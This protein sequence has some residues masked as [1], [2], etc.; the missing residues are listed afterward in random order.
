MR[1]RLR[2]RVAAAPGR[3]HFPRRPL[4]I[5]RDGRTVRR[6][7]RLAG[8]AVC[9]AALGLSFASASATAQTQGH[10]VA[11]KMA[12]IDC[13][14]VPSATRVA[15]YRRLLTRLVT[16]KCKETRL[17][18]SDKLV[19]AQQILAHDGY[20]HYSLLRLM[21]LLDRSI[22]NSIGFRQ[23]CGQVLAALIVLIEK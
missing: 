2:T 7:L 14:C 8:I 20:G 9:L 12:A 16:R 6:V 3:P 23:S 13:K 22:P 15:T 17:R 11:Y 21:R 5:C 19:R 18:L 10:S 1:R 4:K